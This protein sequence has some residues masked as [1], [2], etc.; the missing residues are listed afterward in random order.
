[1]RASEAGVDDADLATKKRSRVV[2]EEGSGSSRRQPVGVRSSSDQWGPKQ[3]S[4]SHEQGQ[5]SSTVVSHQHREVREGGWGMGTSGKEKPA[6][7]PRSSSS[8]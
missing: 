4:S 6:A 7:G 2:N 1:M 5:S 3:W 8:G